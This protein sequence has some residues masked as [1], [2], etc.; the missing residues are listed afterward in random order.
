V[1]YPPSFDVSVRDGQLGLAGD[2]AQLPIIFG[3]SSLGTNATAY[4]LTDPNE[5]VDTLGHGPLTE[6]G[7]PVIKAVGGAILVKLQGSVAAANSAVTVTRVATS[8]GTIVLSGSANRDARCWIEILKTTDALGS[9]SFRYSLDNRITW[10]EEITIPSGGA[11]AIPDFGVTATFTLQAGTPDFE[12]GDLFSWTSTCAMWNTTNLAAGVTA[13][14]ASPYLIGRKIQKVAF[15]GIPAD[16]ATAATN[17]AAVATHMATLENSDHFARAMVD[18]GS[19][20]TTANCLANFVAVF[21]DT[22]V[23]ACYGRCERITDDPIAGLGQP[24]VSVLVPAFIRACVAE[25]S[26]NLGRVESGPLPGVNPKTLSQDEE[27]STAF[28]GDNKIIT[29]RSNRNMVGGAYITNGY[30]KSPQGSDFQYWDY[31]IVCD[32]R[33]ET[34]VKAIVKWTLAKLEAMA[35]GTGFLHPVSAERVQKSLVMPLKTA[36]DGPTVDG[37][38]RHV[39]AAQTIVATAYDFLA[40]R[41][42]KVTDRFVPLVPVEGGTITAGLTR[43]VEA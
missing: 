8:V 9:G 7:A 25:I 23:A 38:P 41:V 27:K 34:I 5:A 18:A 14:L 37:N 6:L 28:T 42:L 40:T 39:S 17:A 10:S 43:T 2:L 29:L 13:L 36:M 26:E 32:R 22:R 1:S 21:S 30:L 19:I 15:A 12:D 20:D 11:F 31:G 4:L 3:V 35:D 24:F 33:C 16:A